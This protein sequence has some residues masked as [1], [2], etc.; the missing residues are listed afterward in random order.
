MLRELNKSLIK[1]ITPLVSNTKDY[2]GNVI[3]VPVII[4]YPHMD[5][6]KESYPC[7]T[8]QFLNS[9]ENLQHTDVNSFTVLS[10]VIPGKVDVVNAP[11]IYD[12]SFQIDI[13]SDNPITRDA[14]VSSF[15]TRM[16]KRGLINIE[17]SDNDSLPCRYTSGKLLSND[18]LDEHNEVVFRNTFDILIQSPIFSLEDFVSTST[19]VGSIN[20][21]IKNKEDK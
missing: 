9:D 21:Q 1:H 10:S 15:M 5:L 19:V 13:W 11:T 6:K 8:I 20:T 7:V 4:K 14:I 17:Y 2:Y 18:Y 12:F 16:P 3:D